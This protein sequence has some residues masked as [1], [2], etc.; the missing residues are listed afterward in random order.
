MNS[1]LNWPLIRNTNLINGITESNVS[2]NRT[3]RRFSRGLLIGLMMAVA[4]A[5]PFAAT[6][7]F[8]QTNL[9]SDQPGV[10]LFTDP[11]L[12]NAW[13][14]AF[15]PSGNLWVS[16]A[17]TGVS[18][19]YRADGRPVRSAVTIPSSDVRGTG[20]PTGQVYNSTDEF[21]VSL[22]GVS[23]PA[24]FIFATEDGTISGWNSSV[25]P[26][27]SVIV[28][29]N[30]S[31]HSVYKGLALGFDSDTGENFLYAAD[32]YN[33]AVDM[34]D[35]SFHW[36]ESFTGPALPDGY[37]PFNVAFIRG[38][39]YVTYAKQKAPDNMDDEA[40]FGHGYLD[41]FSASGR[42]LKRLVAGAALN[43]PW[44]M[45]LVPGGFGPM[46]GLLLVGNFGDGRIHLYHP[47]TGQYYGSLTNQRGNPLVIEGLWGLIF[48]NEFQP[49][50]F[51]GDDY[52]D[53]YGGTRLLYF[54]AG[55]DEEEHGL[56]GILRL[57]PGQDDVLRSPLL[58]N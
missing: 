45:A 1:S 13:G 12:I 34:F 43:S 21:P 31:K 8:Q 27:A 10:A 16:A 24:R 48:G 9:V 18:P 52:D 23:G 55:P 11:N 42:F 14:L 57:V 58:P 41:I 40:G 20:S 29:D 44:G 5:A 22:S 25:N 33:G 50:P 37:A 28:V 39:V 38:R 3:G 53:S 7:R 30:S 26:N 6:I 49:S 17:D 35:S 51:P 15:S 54:S 36:L 19:I 46:S 2:R 4:V 56:V 32:F 47:E